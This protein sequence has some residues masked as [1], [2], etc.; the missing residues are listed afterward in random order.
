MDRETQIKAQIYALTKKLGEDT[1]V[2]RYALKNKI[3]ALKR[4]LATIQYNKNWS[5]HLAR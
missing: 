5:D 4:E 3:L 2:N 1:N